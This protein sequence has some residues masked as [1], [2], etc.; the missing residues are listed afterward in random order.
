MVNLVGGA[1]PSVLEA[2]RLLRAA[3][4]TYV[5]VAARDVGAPPW[6]WVYLP[7][8]SLRPY[9]VGSASAAVA[10]LAPPGF[11]S[12]YVEMSGR[13]PVPP[14]EAGRAAL[15]AL[16]ELGMIGSPADVRFAEVR[17]IPQAYVIHDRAY[18]P[19]RN[20]VREWLAEHDVLV[21]GRSGNWEYS[22]MEDALLG[23][24]QA[25][26]QLKR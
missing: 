5:N 15:E 24:R 22:S 3:T 26:R 6:H 14:A 8:P 20:A 10:S 9:R 4:V 2:A 19:A 12:F 11:R 1:P 23:G 7:E 18:G 17:T 16:L 25:A 13:E 21:A